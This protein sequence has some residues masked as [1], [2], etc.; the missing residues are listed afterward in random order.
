MQERA[1]LQCIH[2]SILS[3]EFICRL[4]EPA[5]QYTDYHRHNLQLLY[6]GHEL[7]WAL[8]SDSNA[9]LDSV[10]ESLQQAN[11]PCFPDPRYE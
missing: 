2:H 5:E 3:I 10:I 6:V 11:L 7:T 1:H 4:C 9:S 8:Q